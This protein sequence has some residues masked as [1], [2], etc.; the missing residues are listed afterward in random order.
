MPPRHSVLPPIQIDRRNGPELIQ[1]ALRKV[2]E[3]SG[4]QLNDFSP[5]SPIMAL[6]EGQVFAQEE[7]LQ[8]ANQFPESVLMEWIGPFVG[9][10]RRLGSG[11]LVEL[12]FTIKPT[13]QDFVI[14]S[15]FQVQTQPFEENR[16]SVVFVT[17]ER[18]TIAQ[19]Q[20][21]GKVNATSLLRSVRSNVPAHTITKTISPLTGIVSV[22]NQNAAVGGQN[23]ELTSEVKERI[24]SLIHRKN[25]V[26]QEDWE[27]FFTD[28]LGPNTITKVLPRRSSRFVENETLHSEQSAIS[29]F[30][31]NPDG[32]PISRLQQDSFNKLVRL[33]LPISYQGFVY[34]LEVNP[35]DF[36][37]SLTYDPVKDYATDLGVLSNKVMEQ[38]GII[39]RPK[40]TFPLSYTPTINDIESAL[41]NRFSLTFEGV[42]RYT[43][44]DISSLSAFVTPKGLLEQQ[45]TMDVKK[46][47][48]GEFLNENDLVSEVDFLGKQLF[49]KV[50]KPFS[51]S[52][53]SKTFYANTNKLKLQVVRPYKYGDYFAGDVVVIADE[54][55]YVK[56]NHFNDVRRNLSSSEQTK[57]TESLIQTDTLSD[58]LV[59]R[60]W[61]P[62]TDLK[63]NTDTNGVPDVLEFKHSD[64]SFD[65]ANVPLVRP[66]GGKV[67]GWPVWV[68]NEDFTTQTTTANLN[69]LQI[70]R[71]VDNKTTTI[72]ELEHGIDYRVGQY[73]KTLYG[74]DNNL[75][76]CYVSAN[77]DEK[78]SFGRVTKAFRYIEDRKT[79]IGETLNKLIE[80]KN[81]EPVVVSQ[82][83][84][85]AA[86]NVHE[87]NPFKYGTRFRLGEYV[88]DQSGN[89]YFVLKDFTPYTK[90]IKKLEDDGMLIKTDNYLIQPSFVVKKGEDFGPAEANKS[91]GV[92]DGKGDVVGV[93]I[94]SEGD[95]GTK[96]WIR[97]SSN[98]PPYRDLQRLNTNDV[99]T[100]HNG[101]S[102]EKYKILKP[103]VPLSNPDFY[104]D[105]EAW[106]VTNE[107]ETKPYI[108]NTYNTEDVISQN[109]YL[110]YRVIRPF[111]PHTD[112]LS[113]LEQAEEKG[114]VQKIVTKAPKLTQRLSDG[115]SVNGMGKA[116][117]TL[118]SKN[119]PLVSQ[120]LSYR[121]DK[122]QT[123]TNLV[124]YDE[125]GT[126]FL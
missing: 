107:D 83:V 6:I 57:R 74:S 67:A 119:D 88:R 38:L 55:Y 63:T 109:S 87:L 99:V 48:H 106:E 103:F 65:I 76:H 116:Q 4:G 9:A 45:I 58:A 71:L 62:N 102:T 110:F 39:M 1:S 66:K 92:V 20:T 17:N 22:D 54:L 43:D 82:F 79:N 25:P 36:R 64:V 11:A 85:C 98:F 91:I 28:I 23:P 8:F 33:R 68:V 78:I 30:V 80:N 18:L 15:G 101:Y 19:G 35:V 122:T 60:D 124:D 61:E 3:A 29:F 108:D 46:Y 90:N 27:D 114:Y 49:F 115:I 32:T 47:H 34:P 120:T 111:T 81:L 10:Q 95:D 112:D 72:F 40:S 105:K 70:Q 96:M 26:S 2:Y 123:T 89:F 118:T 59:Y 53:Y 94:G 93:W 52:T 50:L 69:S 5:G 113:T 97:V 42:N 7:L 56:R 16:P 21:T 86:Q 73:V 126:L 14:F 37:L 121:M 44:P 104:M 13:D 51:P 31:L 75:T 24:F 77:E 84:N 125:T 117:I 41:V 100:L 12:T